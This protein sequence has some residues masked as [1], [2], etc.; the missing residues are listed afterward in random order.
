MRLT[1]E[2]LGHLGDG[3]ASGPVYIPR[4]LPGEVVEGEVIEGR[5]NAPSIVTPSSDRRRPPCRHYATC[6]GCSMMH[7]TDRFVAEWKMDVVRSAL[8]AQGLETVIE[9]INTSPDRSR[10]RAT[11]SGKRTGKGAI[12]GFHGRASLSVIDLVDCHLLQSEIVA[13][14]PLLRKIT[15]AGSS[16]KGEL[17]LTVTNTDDGL[18]LAVSGGKP[19]EPTLYAELTALAE[20]ADLARI[21]WDGETLASRRPA[22][23]R[24][25]RSL[26]SVPPG[27]FLQAT[28]QGEAVLLSLVR[29][30]VG[31]ARRVADLFAGAG[32][33]SLPLAEQA[34]VLA[35]ESTGHMLS[36][37]AAGARHTSGLKAVITQVRDLFRRPLLPDELN[38]FD[39]IIL[40]PPRAGAQA[41]ATEIAR[42]RVPVVAYVSC[43]PVTFARDAKI[44]S[45][46][47]YRMAWLHVVDQFRW[48][49]HIEL[50]AKFYRG[51]DLS[52]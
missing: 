17:S 38:D 44:L 37:L 11:F 50:A 52:R 32:T 40:D 33:F 18:D 51:P 15:A 25:G 24:F 19:M 39:A 28:P 14:L 13:A 31:D 43:N 1:I 49:P 21:S 20:S 35:A 30:A 3:I 46:E 10:R 16:R 2:R 23:L 41:Q 36:A 27:S 22:R 45:D 34:E 9:G 5:M 7:A 29:R 26:V 8:A 48:S 4:T 47:G 6:G 42:S 12:V